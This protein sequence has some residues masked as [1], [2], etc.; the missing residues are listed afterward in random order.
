VDGLVFPILSPPV[1]PVKALI[2]VL[3]E[4]E[5]DDMVLVKKVRIILE[6][7]V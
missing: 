6:A 4:L 3:D 5:V 2:A 7:K 1:E